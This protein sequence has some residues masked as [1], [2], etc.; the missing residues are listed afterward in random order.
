MLLLISAVFVAASQV[1]S[2]TS[3]TPTSGR[4][5]TL[6][7]ISG[8]N[9]SAVPANDIVYFGAVRG[10]VISASATQ[11]TVSVP[12]GSSFAPIAA[13]VNGLTGYSSS[14]F[15][16]TFSGGAALSSASYLP[17]SDLA[18][19]TLPY[20]AAASDLDGDGKPDIVVA[21]YTSGTISVYRNIGVNDSSGASVFAAAVEFAAGSNPW[22]LAIGDLDGDG[23]LDIA[24][25]N[26]PGSTVSVLWNTSVAGT[27]DAGSFAAKV[28]FPT[29]GS[30]Y[31]IAI[32]DLDGDGKPDIVATNRFGSSFSVLR[33]VGAIGAIAFAA[34]I[35]FPT[36]ANTNPYGVAV[37]DLDGD[38]KLDLV[39][40]NSAED[41]LSVFRNTSIAGTIDLAS[42]APGVGI[43]V[44]GT[45][46]A[47]AVADVNGDGKSDIISVNTS[48][49]T[50]SVF[51]NQ[52]SIG[53]ITNASFA[54]G[55]DF[56]LSS[57]PTSIAIADLNGDARPDIVV[58]NENSNKLSIFQ[59]AAT[60]AGSISITS[61][62]SEVDLATATGPFGLAVDDLNGDGRPDLVS[63]NS[64]SNSVSVFGSIVGAPS[65]SLSTTSL[66]FG[67]VALRDSSSQNL[68]IRDLSADTLIV[69]SVYSNRKEL[70]FS[71][72]H[73]ISVGTL[74]FAIL[75]KGDTLGLYSDTVFIRTNSQTPLLKVP[76][77]S[78]IYARPG[79]PVA[80]SVNP[81]SWSNA[82]SFTISWTNQAGT[83]P[84]SRVVYSIDT[85]PRSGP[86]LRGIAASGSSASFPIT[87]VG[88]DTVY[89][90]I[91]DSL[92]NS[93]LDSIGTAIVLFDNHGPTLV[94][95][96]ANLDTVFVQA[97]G[98]LSAIPA[99]V[100]TA[101]EPANESG[102]ETFQLLYRRLDEQAW[103]TVN[104]SNDTLTIPAA[105]FVRNGVV[106]GAEYLIQAADSAGNSTSSGLLSFD[107]RFKTNLTVNVLST[108]P[109]IH[110]LNLPAGQE[111][112]AYRLFSAPYDPEDERPGSLIDPSFGPHAVKGVPYVN[113]RME[114]LLNGAWSDYDSFKDSSIL[115]PGAGFFMVSE[116]QGGAGSLVK[117]ELVRADRM[118]YTGIRLNAGWNLVGDPFLVDVPFDHLIFQGGTP[119]AHYY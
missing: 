82:A 69:D 118:L 111:A 119:Q 60:A 6:V 94:Q 22:G 18:A 113:W 27:I 65:I 62:G 76:V 57:A 107:V 67:I 77:S 104:F 39:V 20:G 72:T 96:N 103:T 99:I 51:Q 105:S 73:G 31:G 92:G 54:A 56:K 11:L 23:K 16:V 7:T 13:T 110:S 12:L 84:V 115:V 50:V 89:F 106:V 29:G 58:A 109:S 38:G 8:T 3:F 15:I 117:P 55:V 33:N 53:N 97:D 49:S 32:A 36:G 9:F 52:S 78:R 75:L 47:V 26:G 34:N 14:P 44:T 21:N 93:S 48:D 91:E 45:P 42:F 100:S 101:T 17:K 41:T 24:V 35:D 64:G 61:F 37:G 1:P 98:T 114:R 95:N 59:N 108:R 2:I 116:N 79:K 70:R 81:S 5:G 66:D 71:A 25:S 102:V 88:R 83:L 80:V 19:S 10:S 112:K 74:S 85:L 40:A 90:F 4:S 28:S 63:A 46:I 87:Q 68:V 86:V 30:G 43:P